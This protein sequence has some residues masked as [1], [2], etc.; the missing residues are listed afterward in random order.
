MSER[1]KLGPSE[2]VGL[3]SLETRRETPFNATPILITAVQPLKTGKGLLELDFVRLLRPIRATT[4]RDKV[5]VRHRGPGIIL[6]TANGPEIDSELV[7]ISRLTDQWLKQFCPCLIHAYPPS[8]SPAFDYGPDKSPQAYLDYFMGRDPASVVSGAREDQFAKDEPKPLLRLSGRMEFQRTFSGLDGWRLLRGAHPYSMDDKWF[9]YATW[10]GDRAGWLEFRRSWTCFPVWRVR[11]QVEGSN[12][13]TRYADVNLDERQYG[14][15]TRHYEAAALEAVIGHILGQ[16]PAW[17]SPHNEDRRR[18]RCDWGLEEHS[19]GISDSEL[20]AFLADPPDPQAGI[21]M[22]AYPLGD[23][24]GRRGFLQHLFDVGYTLLFEA[25]AAVWDH[26]A[27]P[28]VYW[29]TLMGQAAG[30]GG[31]GKVAIRRTLRK[32]ISDALRAIPPLPAQTDFRAFQ[33]WNRAALAN[34]GDPGGVASVIEHYSAILGST[35]LAGAKAPVGTVLIGPWPMPIQAVAGARPPTLTAEEF[36]EILTVVASGRIRAFSV[37]QPWA[38]AILH[39][40]KDVENRTWE[41]SYRGWA[42]LHASKTVSEGATPDMQTGGVLGLVEIVGCVTE[43]ASPWF[44]GPFGWKL[45]R[46]LSVPFVSCRGYP[47]MFTPS[48]SVLDLIA[49]ILR[50]SKDAAI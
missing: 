33:D 17:P 28:R 34:I 5:T 30:V 18:V 35:S 39:R 8:L 11:F 7:A 25:T 1:L 23:P 44:I 12:V 9:V 41:T 4:E 31:K 40:G 45:G 29:G 2:W 13:V 20:Q 10:E 32:F 27:E 24:A 21:A 49:A 19:Y 37:R 42:L 3:L 48:L 38:D 15:G 46:T 36:A 16:W 6:G 50:T 47:G 14:F 26:L 22:A 43:S